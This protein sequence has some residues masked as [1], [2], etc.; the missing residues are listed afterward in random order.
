MA[1]RIEDYAMLG[2]CRSAA[3]VDRH[4]SIDWLCLPRFDSDALFAALLGNPEHGRW[5]IAPVGAFSSTRHYRYGS[6]VLET[7][8]ETEDGAVALL[9]FMV[10]SRDDDVHNHVVRIVRGLRGRVPLRMQLQLRF[11]YGRTI[12]W[13]S[14]IDGGLQA[15]AGPDQIA[16]RSPQPMYGHG[17]ATEA[18]FALEAGGK[19]NVTVVVAGF[20]IPREV[21]A[22]Q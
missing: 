19:D 12:P 4:G 3:L 13:V 7:E 21:T 2:N 22:R 18:D 14:Q 6:L 20:R 16:L 17:F 9:D 11:N 15:I 1:A 10:A 5:S 8:F